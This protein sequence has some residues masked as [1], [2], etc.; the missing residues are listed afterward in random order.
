MYRYFDYCD[1][2]GIEIF[3]DNTYSL[4]IKESDLDKMNKF[5]SKDYRC[6]KI[7]YKH[8]KDSLIRSQGKFSLNDDD[9]NKI[10]NME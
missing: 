3:D 8:N 2:K 6:L 1:K 7:E 4:L 5:I 10:R 9:K